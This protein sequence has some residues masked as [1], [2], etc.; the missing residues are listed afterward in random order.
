MADISKCK[1]TDCPLKEK[2]YRFTAPTGERQSWFT[3]TPFKDG[4][5]EYYWDNKTGSYGKTAHL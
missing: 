5:C 3:E 1:G 2:C 4:E